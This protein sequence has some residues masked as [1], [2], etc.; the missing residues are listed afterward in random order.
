MYSQTLYK[1]IKATCDF[2]NVGTECELLL[3]E[4]NG[5]V[6][7]FNIYNIYD[8]CGADTLLGGGASTLDAVRH[9][10]AQKTVVTGSTHEAFNAHP[11]LARALADQRRA[12]AAAIG[13]ADAVAAAVST[14]RTTRADG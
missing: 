7:A 2:N 6:G 8:D 5:Q 14:G 11:A 3:L 9:T 10:R 1:K 4:M 12:T 13:D